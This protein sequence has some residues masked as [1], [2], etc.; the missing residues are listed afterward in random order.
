[1]EIVL[2]IGGIILSIAGIIGCIIPAIPGPPLNY[3]ALLLLYL[4]D[5]EAFSPTFLIIT[6][7]ITIIITFIDYLLPIFGA[8]KYGVSK[9]GIW[10]SVIGMIFGIFFFPP[11]GMIFGLFI[12]A[13]VG[14][15]L[16]GKEQSEAL[17]AGFISFVLSLT[18]IVIKLGVSIILTFYFIGYYI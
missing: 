15:I 4:Y 14:E 8:K 17:K 9:Y 10:G 1:V 18:G 11:F 12:G 16:F 3:T 5:S 7:I 13:F 6:A 2:L